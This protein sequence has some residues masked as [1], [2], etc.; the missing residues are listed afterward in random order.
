MLPVA[1]RRGVY[2][3]GDWC[4]PVS[5]QKLTNFLNGYAVLDYLPRL[6][7]FLSFNEN[8]LL[9]MVNNT[10]HEGALLQEPDYRPVIN[11]TSYGPSRFNKETEYHINI[12]AYKRLADW[13]AFLKAEDVYDNTRIILVSD[14]GSQISYVTRAKPGMPS[15]FDN[16]HPILL[17]KDFDSSGKLVTDNTFMTTA[18]VPLLALMGE[19]DKPVNPFTSNEITNLAKEKPLYIA[20]SGTIHLADPNAFQIILDPKLDW[21]VHGGIFDESNWK[22]VAE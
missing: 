18:D 14:H 4:A 5:G 8:T 7:D 13:F 10:T 1:F 19:I 15:N 20:N 12:A 21:Y 6:T 11:V 16:L 3:Y 17:V 2:Q 22:K 9:L